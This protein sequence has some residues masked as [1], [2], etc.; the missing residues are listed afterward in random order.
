[1][2]PPHLVAQNKGLTISGKATA[3]SL[4]CTA[5]RRHAQLSHLMLKALLSSDDRDPD[6][7]RI[8]L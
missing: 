6:Q 2:A 7:A 5:V 3:P 8:A 4:R 1:M